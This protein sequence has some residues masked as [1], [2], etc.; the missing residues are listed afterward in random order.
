MPFNRPPPPPPALI[1]SALTPGLGS[2]LSFVRRLPCFDISQNRLIY[3]R[4][5]QVLVIF[6]FSSFISFFSTQTRALLCSPGWF[7]TLN[8]PA[9]AFQALWFFAV[10]DPGHSTCCVEA[11]CVLTAYIFF[12][13]G[14]S[15][16]HLPPEGEVSCEAEMCISA[17]RRA[18][19]DCV[20]R[21]E[22]WSSL[23]F[24]ML[25]SVVG[26]FLMADLYEF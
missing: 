11:G 17:M 26:I 23:L 15:G 12:P 7:Q 22:S 6:F 4:G 13:S 3:T 1:P 21:K 18:H 19:F 16:L 24:Q 10:T 5:V 9:S 20:G 14:F 2:G 25:K 8:P